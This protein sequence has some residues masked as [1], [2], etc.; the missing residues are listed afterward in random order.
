[1]IVR[2]RSTVASLNVVSERRDELE[3]LVQA[4]DK[5]VE[6]VKLGTRVRKPNPRQCGLG[7]SNTTVVS[8]ALVVVMA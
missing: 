4:Q 8:F 3:A 7:T 5:V 2:M 6:N 1:M